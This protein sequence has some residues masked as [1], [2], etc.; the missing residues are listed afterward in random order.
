MRRFCT[1]KFLFFCC[2]LALP[3]GAQDRLVWTLTEGDQFEVVISQKSEMETLVTRTKVKIDLELIYHMQWK[4][5]AVADNGNFAIEQAFSRMSVRLARSK[6]N[7]L[8]YDTDSGQPPEE[9][10]QPYARVYDKLIGIPFRVEMTPRGE[11]VKVEL[12]VKDRETI[13]QIPETMQARRLFEKKG[14]TEVLNGD[15]FVLPNEAISKGFTWLLT[16][17][18]KMTFGAAEVENVY[19]YQG[20]TP[21][22]LAEFKV[23][24]KI[25]L[26]D[27]PENPSEKSLRL[28]SQ[29][30]SGRILFNPVLG[31]LDSVTLVQEMKTEKPFREMMIETVT[32]VESK[33]GI[34]AK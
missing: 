6:K 8:V 19:T 21:Q 1:V 15:G 29:E 12:N 27:Q 13:E 31:R 18:K 28:I 32:R 14:L 23:D 26:D 2:W 17:N 9:N 33:I 25:E 22:G 34:T 5:L 4:V 3:V 30:H 11:I 20:K 7:D 16:K 10:A 24:S